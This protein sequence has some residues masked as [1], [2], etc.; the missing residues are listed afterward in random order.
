MNL[1]RCTNGHFYD[2]DAYPRCP[3][4][5]GS[6]AQAPN[7]GGV[8]AAYDPNPIAQGASS[9]DTATISFPEGGSPALPD[10]HTDGDNEKTIGFFDS[11]DKQFGVA[12]F[13]PVV[14]WLVCTAGKNRG[15]EYRL[16]VGRN[17]IGRNKENSVVLAGEN[18]VSRSK[19]AVVVYEPNQNIFLAQPGE[20]TE[21]SYVNG[22]VVLGAKQLKKNDRI[23]VGDVEIM[24]IPCCDECFSWVQDNK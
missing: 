13:N 9:N 18:S 6:L 12:G 16:A 2:A 22:E 3:H 10:K 19:H 11:A 7:V 5:D 4:C 8:T 14:G 23:K 20:A 17:F 21:L 24:L 15:K 1:Q